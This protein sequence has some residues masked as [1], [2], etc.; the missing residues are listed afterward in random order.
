[1]STQPGAVAPFMQGEVVTPSAVIDPQSFAGH[2][3]LNVIRDLIH[4]AAFH[5]E[6]DKNSALDA[7]DAFEKRFIPSQDQKHVVAEG[8]LAGREDVSQRKPPQ[9]GGAPVPVNV[10]QI[11]YNALARALMAAQREAEQESSGSHAAPPATPA[12]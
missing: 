7:V 10:P 2:D 1:M 6:G 11:D 5:T 3:F 9:T 4:R 8:E 12:E